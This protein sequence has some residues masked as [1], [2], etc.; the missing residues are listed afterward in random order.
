M[1]CNRIQTLFWLSFCLDS[2]CL[3][4]RYYFSLFINPILRCKCLQY[5]F[6]YKECYRERLQILVEIRPGI[7]RSSIQHAEST[8]LELILLICSISDHVNSK[9]I[10]SLHIRVWSKGLAIIR[11]S[12][13][14]GMHEDPS[15]SFQV[16]YSVHI[17]V[18]TC[19][20]MYMYI[21]LPIACLQ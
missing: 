4:P 5:C 19:M 12:A 15:R 1:Y 9:L 10:I 21:P 11:S 17:I 6:K 14:F 18:C 16:A 8:D 2:Y 7:C 20:Y 3:R 13:K